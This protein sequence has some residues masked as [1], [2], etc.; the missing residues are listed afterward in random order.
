MEFS[1]IITTDKIFG[2]VRFTDKDFNNSKG[3]NE[4]VQNNLR[5]DDE[6]KHSN[7]Q[8]CMHYNDSNDQKFGCRT[9]AILNYFV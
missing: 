3:I 4:F 7:G 1:K 5:D 2:T 9:H 6:L 8:W